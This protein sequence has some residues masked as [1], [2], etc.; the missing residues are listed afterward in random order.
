MSSYIV[1]LSSV[2]KGIS[3]SFLNALIRE[4]KFSVGILDREQFMVNFVD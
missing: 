1:L 4:I 3:L 2:D